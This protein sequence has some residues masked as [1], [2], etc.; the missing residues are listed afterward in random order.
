MHTVEQ[1]NDGH[2]FSSSVQERSAGKREAQGWTVKKR[3]CSAG[4]NKTVQKRRSQ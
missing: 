3:K 2:A 1:F 4:Q